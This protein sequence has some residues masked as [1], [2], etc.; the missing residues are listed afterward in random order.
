MSYQYS[1]D[2]RVRV[3]ASA[4]ALFDYLDDH[5]RVAGHMSQPSM[6]I[7]N[8]RMS[9]EFDQAEGREIGG[10]I[11]M[12]GA[13]LGVRLGVQETIIERRPPFRRRRRTVPTS[14][15]LSTTTFHRQRP[16]V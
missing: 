10:R 15:C 11:R 12:T 8:G 2:S 14:G 7:L 9:Y 13:F 6:M 3:Q 1:A 5:R 16:G 4:E